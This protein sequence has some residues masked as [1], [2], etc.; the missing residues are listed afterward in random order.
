LRPFNISSPL[1]RFFTG[2]QPLS[3]HW[4]VQTQRLLLRKMKAIDV[5]S[6]GEIVRDEGVYSQLLADPNQF[7]DEI[8]S[9]V[10]SVDNTKKS[11]I[12]LIGIRK[13]DGKIISAGFLFD[14]ELSYCVH[15]ALHRQGYGYEFVSKLCQ[16]AMQPEIECSNIRAS[17]LRSNQPSRAVLEK[18]GFKFEGLAYRENSLYRGKFAML[19]Y[20]LYIDD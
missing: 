8:A 13:S 16:L 10:E 4:S 3:C 20:C 6:I 15:S 18:V 2:D 5:P 9:I 7:I 12:A 1:R 14:N 17:V 19:D 11:Y